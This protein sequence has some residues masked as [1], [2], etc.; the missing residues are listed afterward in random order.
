[1]LPPV[2]FGDGLNIGECCVGN[3]GLDATFRLLRDP[4]RPPASSR[5]SPRF[6]HRR[7]S[8]R[9]A[10]DFAWLET[11][12]ALLKGKTRAA[13]V[14][15]LAGSADHPASQEFR[16]LSARREEMLAANTGRVNSPRRRKGRRTLRAWRQTRLKAFAQSITPQRFV[17][18]G[19]RELGPTWKPTIK[20]TRSRRRQGAS[21]QRG[22]SFAADEGFRAQ[23][24]A[25]HLAWPHRRRLHFSEANERD[26]D[27]LLFPEV[28][29]PPASRWASF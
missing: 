18:R 13:T 27:Q 12:R 16:C 6:G 2:K 14:F 25:P 9:P 5:W 11:D 17:S 23:S 4:R 24:V 1:M 22:G 20:L 28:G 10:R 8:K 19:A 26:L 29:S 15:A 21:F 7:T 3:L